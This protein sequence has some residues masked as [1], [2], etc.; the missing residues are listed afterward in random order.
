MDV[1]EGKKG[2]S[3]SSMA[4]G[5]EK[6]SAYKRKRLQK[7]NLSLNF[8]SKI[9]KKRFENEQKMCYY[10]KTRVAKNESVQEEDTE[11]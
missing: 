4:E 1:R 9:S 10:T 6:K 2:V 11:K 5:K 3:K 8:E 7:S